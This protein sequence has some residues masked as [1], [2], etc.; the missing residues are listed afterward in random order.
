M[1]TYKNLKKGTKIGLAVSSILAVLTVLTQLGAIPKLIN[2]GLIYSVAAACNAAVMGLLAMWYAFV[3][4][5]KPHGNVLRAVF[6]AF[7]VYLV[8]QSGLASRSDVTPGPSYFLPWTSY[9]L[10]FA[11]LTVAY[12]SGRLN[13]IEKNKKLIVFAG[14]LMIVFALVK[15]FDGHANTF[16]RIYGLFSSAILFTALSC[17]Y[18]ARY[19]EHKAAGLADKADAEEK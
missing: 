6:F 10:M 7:S 19:E 15:L 14:I 11:A 16:S 3:G 17:A 2:I 4:Y 5:K 9:F 13:K 1:E 12:I 8:F 18:I